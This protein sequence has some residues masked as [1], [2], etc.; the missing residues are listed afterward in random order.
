MQL[1]LSFYP[2]SWVRQ[3]LAVVVLSPCMTE[4]GHMERRVETGDKTGRSFGLQSKEPYAV[5]WWD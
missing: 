4:T 1:R 2:D 5:T 3:Q